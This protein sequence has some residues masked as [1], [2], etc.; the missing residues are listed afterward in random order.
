MRTLCALAALGLAATAFA[1]TVKSIDNNSANG[2][3]VTLDDKK[4]I[5]Q[6][7]FV[8]EERE[9]EVPRNRVKSI[10]FNSNTFNPN[11]PRGPFYARAQQIPA[12]KEN[13]SGKTGVAQA[14]RRMEE[15]SGEDRVAKKTP[16]GPQDTIFL[17]SGAQR[18]AHVI[19]IDEK[20]VHLSGGELVDRYTV[21]SIRFATEQ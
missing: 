21:Q 12:D 13:A 2:R 10:E 19:S 1:D 5:I 17:K 18:E 14:A 15:N 8:G 7:R 6:A 11:A 20:S 4:L 9:I 16:A 3:I